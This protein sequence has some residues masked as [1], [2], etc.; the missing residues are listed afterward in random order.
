VGLINKKAEFVVTKGVLENSLVGTCMGLLVGLAIRGFFPR[1]NEIN[2]DWV[3]FILIG[4]L[5]GIASGFERDRKQ[6]LMRRK[7]QLEAEIRQ[8]RVSLLTTEERYK[9]LFNYANDIILIL[10][11]DG[12][13]AELNP[14]FEEIFG[15]SANEW[16]GRSFYDLLT[17]NCRD[18]A[19]KNFWETLKG[20]NPRFILDAVQVRGGVVNLSCASSPVRDAEGE[21]IGAM[22]IARDISESKNLEELQNRFVSHASHELRTPLTAMREFVSLLVDGVVGEITEEQKQY[23]GRVESNIDRLSRIIDNLLLMAQAD[24]EKITLDKR[25]LDLSELLRQVRGDYQAAAAKKNQELILNLEGELPRFHFDPDRM[26]QVLINLLGNAMKYTPDGGKIELGARCEKGIVTAWV[27]DNGVGIDPEQHERIFDRFQQI[28]DGHKFGRK[29]AGLGLAISREIIRLHRGRMWVE[30]QSGVGSCFYF[31]IPVS[32]APKILLVD[33][34]PDLVEMYKDFLAPYHYRVEVAY[35]G[36]EAL[37]KARSQTPDLM[38]LD[39]VMPRMNGYEVIGRLQ[40]SAQT[41]NIPLV[42]L[43]AYGLDQK[44]LNGLGHRLIPALHKPVS[45]N[46]FIGAVR[47]SLGENSEENPAR[48]AIQ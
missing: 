24:E 33:D 2:L 10:E 9:N 31:S 38:V 18:E 14:K 44:R 19:I 23:L 13:F 5:I 29:G 21:V 7:A 8:S 11:S 47:D 42:I 17:S 22:I 28:R 12:R 26:M 37:E 35:N 43:T 16:L 27:K 4:L 48:S 20:G 15:Y 45:M 30:S 40:E 41:C 39:V 46:E 6:V 3:I 25:L 36:E 1:L 32:Q 34:D